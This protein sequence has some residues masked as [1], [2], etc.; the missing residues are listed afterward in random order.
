MARQPSSSIV[1]P[2][3]GLA[4]RSRPGRRLLGNTREQQS[5]LGR[6]S[7]ETP[8][9]KLKDIVVDCERPAHVARFWAAALDDYAIRPYDAAEIER[10]AALGFT[11]E[12]D[13]SV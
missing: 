9:A 8:V 13:P 1:G 6:L 2:A 4:T 3:V 7:R 10:L 5:V 11:P 12:T